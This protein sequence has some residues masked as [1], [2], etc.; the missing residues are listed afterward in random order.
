MTEHDVVDW[1]FENVEA[2]RKLTQGLPV[3]REGDLQYVR[4]VLRQ[5]L[6]ASDPETNPLMQKEEV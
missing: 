6:N 2:A 4:S 3:R 5:V 1:V